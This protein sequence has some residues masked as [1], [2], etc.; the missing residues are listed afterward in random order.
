[1]IRMKRKND[2]R[3]V[4]I[5]NTSP[6]GRCVFVLMP[7]SPPPFLMAVEWLR[8]RYNQEDME[9]VQGQHSVC[10]LNCR[11]VWVCNYRRRSE[12]PVSQII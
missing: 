7:D 9:V 3:G 1:M 5:K 11:A 2:K 12:S 4:N 8:Q 10:L 6:A